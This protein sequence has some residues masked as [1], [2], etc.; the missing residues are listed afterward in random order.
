MAY[1]QTRE[2]NTRR[3]VSGC[4]EVKVW[5][6]EC[7]VKKGG[8]GSVLLCHVSLFTILPIK[9]II[10]S[11]RWRNRYEC[12]LCAILSISNGDFLLQV[13]AASRVA[14]WSCAMCTTCSSASLAR[15]WSQSQFYEVLSSQTRN[16]SRFKTH[17]CVQS[18]HQLVWLIPQI[19]IKARK[20]VLPCL[21]W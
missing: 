13:S 7:A 5:V 20:S 4:F 12:K 15:P 16:K 10:L 8:V 6:C 19:F 21:W 2:V 11:R 3:W 18:R 9:L 17:S 1:V 14:W